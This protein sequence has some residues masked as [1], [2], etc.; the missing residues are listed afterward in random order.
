MIGWAKLPLSIRRLAFAGLNLGLL[1][2][3]YATLVQ[4]RV[5]SHAANADRLRD[6][7]QS[8][9]RFKAVAAKEDSVKDLIARAK[10]A[11]ASG[12]FWAGAGEAAISAALQARLRDMA[13]A[14]GVRL[15][16]LRGLPI[17]DQQ[18]VRSLTIRIEANGALDAIQGLLTAIETETPFLFVGALALRQGVLSGPAGPQSEPILDLQLDVTGLVREGGA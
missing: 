1:L 18:G 11:P 15:R 16:S 14:T 9:G 6:L 2:V 12:E 10:A 7:R 17:A 4:P 3:L 13:E 5:S 8:V